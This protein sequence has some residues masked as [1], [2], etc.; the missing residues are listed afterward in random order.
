[1]SDKTP[2][3]GKKQPTAFE[4]QKGK[5]ITSTEQARRLGALG[6]VKS[7]EKQ[8][9][10]KKFKELAELYMSLPL[11]GKNKESL[12]AAGIPEDDC[13]NMMILIAGLHKAGASGKAAEAKVILEGIGQYTT[14]SEVTMQG[15]AEIIIGKGD[16]NE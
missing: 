2:P 16:K 5:G 10:K 12:M 15:D 11:K 1:M 14:K 13:N 4:N 7:Q 8:K 9:E 3:K 6:G